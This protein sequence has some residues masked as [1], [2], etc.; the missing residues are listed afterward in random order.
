MPLRINNNIS[1]M[2]SRRRLNANN[3][4]LGIRLERLSSGLRINRASDDAAGLSVREGMR[5]EISGLKMNVLNA[6]QGSN[7]VQVAEGS[8]NEINAILIRMRELSVQSASSTINDQNREALQA[9]YSQLTSEIDRIAMST[10]YNDQNLL[11]GFGN[12]IDAD[13]TALTISD[14]S[15]VMNVK[16]TGALTGSYLF[17]DLGGDDADGNITLG[18]GVVTQTIRVA[19][20]LDGNDVATGTSMIA[21]FDRL[22]IQVTLAG[23]D[24]ENAT[25]SYTDGDLDGQTIII[26]GGTGGS[27]QVGPDDG[28]NDRIE[29]SIDDMRASGTL[30]NLNT[31]SIA[32][33]TSSRASITTIDEAIFKVANQRGDLGAYQNR[34]A[35]TISFTENEIENIQNSESS[36]SDADIAAEVTAFTRAQ[37]L[38]QA[39]TSMLAQ[40]NVVP[41]TAVSL[42]QS[43]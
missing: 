27:L 17:E 25:G 19:T 14:T 15:G 31:T 29:L 24:V 41:Q 40:A 1:A 18:N 13:S 23:T 37:I 11:A 36:I 28:V 43:L 38:S 5:A 9:E 4:D 6:E 2:N 3:Q 33:L 39:A 10:T 32:T 16:I 34:L 8:L 26:N 20:M 22:G 42:L 35:F 30:L 21:N 7:L 12:N